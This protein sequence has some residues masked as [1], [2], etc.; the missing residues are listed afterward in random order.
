VH[1][2]GFQARGHHLGDAGL[3]QRRGV[4][5]REAPALLEGEAGAAQR[6]GEDAALGLGDGGGAEIHYSTLPLS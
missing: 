5:G 1:V 4:V 2:V 6:V 3:G